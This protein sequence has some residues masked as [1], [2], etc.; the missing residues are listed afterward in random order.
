L[1]K[2]TLVSIAVAFLVGIAGVIWIC[3]ISFK[4][5]VMSFDSTNAPGA[6]A[7]PVPTRPPQPVV[8]AP[9]AAP[10]REDVFPT[11]IPTMVPTRAPVVVT[12]E[13]VRP[14]GPPPP[15]G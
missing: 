6:L 4:G 14:N 8:A 5:S 3:Y 12:P 15:D 2:S 9:A 11:F 1:Q 7:T 13:P 10:V